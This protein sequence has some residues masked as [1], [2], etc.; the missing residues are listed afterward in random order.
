M[1]TNLLILIGLALSP[2]LLTALFHADKAQR[3]NHGFGA[4]HMQSVPDTRGQQLARSPG[5]R[6][7]P[8]VTRNCWRTT[9]R[10]PHFPVSVETE[11][12][13]ECCPCP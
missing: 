6:L 9:S 1:D 2:G 11:S 5:N 13:R 7:N 8:S 3:E 10:S 4:A 12:H